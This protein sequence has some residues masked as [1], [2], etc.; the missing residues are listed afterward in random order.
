MLIMTLGILWCKIA[1]R[2]FNRMPQ[3][4]NIQLSQSAWIYFIGTFN[5]FL[6]KLCA[7]T[8]G[9]DLKLFFVALAGLYTMS[10]TGTY[11]SSLN[12]IYTVILA[13]GTLPALYARYETQVDTIAARCIK[14]VKNLSQLFHVKVLDK[15]PR[16]RKLN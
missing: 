14:G 5:W 8:S 12:L 16:H 4:I 10:T 9:K 11:I 6:L 3:E 7:I 13:L 1:A 2:I 15:I